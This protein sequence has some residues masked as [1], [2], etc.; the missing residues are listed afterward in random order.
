MATCLLIV[1]SYDN[2]IV[3]YYM[4]RIERFFS[5]VVIKICLYY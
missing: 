1:L 3:I 5:S 2:D 4:V